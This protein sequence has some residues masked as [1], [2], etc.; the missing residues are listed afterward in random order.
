MDELKI[1]HLITT[2]GRE[3]ELIKAVLEDNDI[4]VIVRHD[5]FGG[6]SMIYM[7]FSAY[8]VELYVAEDDYERAKELLSDLNIDSE[9]KEVQ[10]KNEFSREDKQIGEQESRGFNKTGKAQ[11]K[12]ADEENDKTLSYYLIQA[13]KI[14]IIF[15]L[16]FNLFALIF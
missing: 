4:A 11:E 7:G 3:A 8:N 13:A 5:E 12:E 10:D 6:Y 2:G 14:I 9:Q 1:V 15:Y 16:L